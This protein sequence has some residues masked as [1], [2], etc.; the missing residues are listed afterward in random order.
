MLHEHKQ[1]LILNSDYSLLTIMHWQKAIVLSVRHGYNK[2]L[3]VEILDFY[4]DDYICGVNNKKHPIPAVAKTVKFLKVFNHTVKFSRMNLFIRDNYTCQYCGIRKEISDLTYDHV[5]P[6]S[7]WLNDR[8][9][10]TSWTN[11]VTACTRC[12]R[13]KSNRTPAQAN[14]PIKNL[15][16]APRKHEKYLPVTSYLA[17]IRSNIPEEWVYYLPGSYQ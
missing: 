8:A 3:G 15:P 12:N 4:K 10:P 17:N 13:K 2:N 6:K 14:M 11:I 16:I 1:C 7:A 9:S 5:I